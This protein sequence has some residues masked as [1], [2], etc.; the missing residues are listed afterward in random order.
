MFRVIVYLLVCA[1]IGWLTGYFV[2]RVDQY[3]RVREG[4]VPRSHWSIDLFFVR[5]IG[6]SVFLLATLLYYF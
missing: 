6:I 2:C 3:Y 4:K 5:L 1:L